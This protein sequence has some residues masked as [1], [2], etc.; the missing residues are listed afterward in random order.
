MCFSFQKQGQHSFNYINSDLGRTGG[1][2]RAHALT[3]SAPSG[4]A[5]DDIFTEDPIYSSIDYVDNT[6]LHLT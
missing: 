2:N 1:N 3:L 6:Y 5:L 4:I